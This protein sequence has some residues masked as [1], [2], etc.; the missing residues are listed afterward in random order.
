MSRVQ[1]DRHYEASWKKLTPVPG[2]IVTIVLSLLLLIAYLRGS[3]FTGASVNF[4]E[5]NRDTVAIVVQIISV[6]LGILN[7]WALRTLCIE[8]YHSAE[9]RTNS[10]RKGTYTIGTAALGVQTPPAQH[11]Q[12][13][14]CLAYFPP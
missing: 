13:N 3:T 6:F 12:I 10:S 9:L 1:D 7:S 4:V 14:Q 11:F 2:L 5:N 8:R